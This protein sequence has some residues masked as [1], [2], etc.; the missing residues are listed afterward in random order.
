MD[1]TSTV[2]VVV[3]TATAAANGQNVGDI[4]IIISE[5][6]ADALL[7]SAEAAAD[8]CSG[9]LERRRDSVMWK[10][11]TEAGKTVDTSSTNSIG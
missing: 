5:G 4:S 1:G 2:K 3:A 7:S 8:A 6:L 9:I 11:V 10:R